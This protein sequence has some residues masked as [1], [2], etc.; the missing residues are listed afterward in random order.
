MK[1]KN[2]R[3]GLTSVQLKPSI[4]R[5]LEAYAKRGISKSEI[6]NHALRE[7]LL[8]KEFA[9]IR[10]RLVPFAQAQGLYTDEDVDRALA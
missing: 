5:M 10:N 6:I 2:K 8:E 4:A 3:K 7:Y 9:A 1:K